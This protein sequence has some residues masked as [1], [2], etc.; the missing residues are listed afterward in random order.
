M[1]DTG[2]NLASDLI[3]CGGGDFA[4]DDLQNNFVI[5]N[6]FDVVRGTM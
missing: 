2:V 3:T 1:V 5:V 4:R 6:P